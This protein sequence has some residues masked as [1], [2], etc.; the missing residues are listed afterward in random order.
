MIS[1]QLRKYQGG[2]E[3]VEV[4]LVIPLLFFL[5]FGIINGGLAIFNYNTLV[6]ATLEGARCGS[7][8]GS[9]GQPDN[10][11]A[12]E[13][14]VDCVQRYAVGLNLPDGDVT[15][16]FVLD[17]LAVP[18]VVVETKFKFRPIAPLFVPSF[19]MRSKAS[20]IVFY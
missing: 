3:I 13:A 1:V 15:A 17:T 7:V 12:K 8:L 16:N 5:I 19:D 11:K 14:V 10:N 9:K 18:T 6:A 4:A 2:T 20:M